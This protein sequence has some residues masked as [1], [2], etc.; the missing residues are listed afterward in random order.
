MSQADPSSDQF[1]LGTSIGSRSR[2]S[3]L[4]SGSQ[5]SWVNRRSQV[6]TSSGSS[7]VRC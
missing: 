5:W 2:R 7:T 4:R 3:P 6:S 1:C